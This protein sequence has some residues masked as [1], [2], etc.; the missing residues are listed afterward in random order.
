MAKLGRNARR[1][2]EAVSRFRHPESQGNRE[3]AVSKDDGTAASDLQGLFGPVLARFLHADRIPE[4]GAGQAF[5]RT[6][7]E[8]N[9]SHCW[10]ED[11]K[12]PE[13]CR[14]LLQTCHTSKVI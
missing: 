13:I 3:A 10:P 11:G 1:D 4:A 9:G 8:A 2:R 14:E 7:S 5:I 6:R 12:S